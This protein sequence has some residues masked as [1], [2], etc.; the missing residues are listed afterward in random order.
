MHEGSWGAEGSNQVWLN[1]RDRLDL[2]P[3]LSR[4][5]LRLREICSSSTTWQTS[6]LATRLVQQLC[7]ELLLLESS[8]W[9][10]LITTGAAR[11]YAELRFLTHNDQFTELRTA[12]SSPS[13]NDGVLNEHQLARLNDIQ[14]RDGI[15]PDIDPAFWATG[16]K[17]APPQQTT[18]AVALAAA[19]CPN[20]QLQRSDDEIDEV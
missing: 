5:T 14:T 9:Q 4:R 17:D 19:D 18:C 11:D 1:P 8:D 10:F 13:S 16:A 15:F 7:R 20:V 6:E 3:S 2:H 12:S